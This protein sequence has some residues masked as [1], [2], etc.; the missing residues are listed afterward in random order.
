MTTIQQARQ[1]VGNQIGLPETF[2][3]SVAAYREL[4][5][6]K[7]IE[8]NQAVLRYVLANPANFLP[9]QV[10][11]ARTQVSNSANY[12]YDETSNA[13]AFWEEFESQV[14]RA[15]TAVASVGEGAL[16]SVSLVGNLLPA[17]VIVGIVVLALPYIRQA[18]KE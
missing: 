3:G 7:Q 2:D 1:I 11:V 8:L 13:S 10:A 14:T 15:A 12:Q 18:A 4:T 17:L 6:Q 9:A 5:P 16:T